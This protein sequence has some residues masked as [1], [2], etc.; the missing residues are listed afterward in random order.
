MQNYKFGKMITTLV[1]AAMLFCCLGCFSIS[2]SAAAKTDI[3]RDDLVVWY[4]AS[5]NSNG[6]QDYETTV[7]KDLTGNGN[8]MTV[9]L[10]ETNYWTDNAFHAE[11]NPTY[12]PDAV[13][14]VVNGDAYTVEMVLGEVD[15]TA[16]HWITLMCS[17]NDEFSLFV[18]QENDVLEYKY[19]DDNRDRPEVADGGNL[20]KNS[21]LSITFALTDPEAPLCTVYVNGVALDTGVPTVANIA[22]TLMW[23]HDSPARAWGGDVYGFRF[24]D[25]ALS[26]E[27]VAKNAS[28]DERNYRSGNYF[29]PEIEYDGSSEVIGGEDG[30][31]Y[32]SNIVTLSEAT[33]LVGTIGEYGCDN[34]HYLHLYGEHQGLKIMATTNDDGTITGNPFF[35]V[36]YPKFIRRAGLEQLSADDVKYIVVKIKVQ[37]EIEDLLFWG[38]SGE[39]ATRGGIDSCL[40]DNY[41]ECTGE[42][43]YMLFNMEDL[44]SGHINNFAFE[45]VNPAADAVVYI[46]EIAMFADEASAYTYAGQNAET[47]P[48]TTDAPTTETPTA[49]PSDETS[50]PEDLEDS[51]AAGAGNDTVA[52][53]ETTEEEQGGCGAVLSGAGVFSILGLTVLLLRK[54]KE[55]YC[56]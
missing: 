19:N 56:I 10:D 5:N 36:N 3:V 28:A 34:M 54:K 16:T 47:E 14:D 53:T 25:R 39:N 43:E 55:S 30:I 6:L 46:E 50:A 42:T 18:R 51:T 17:D 9:K 26:A 20:I 33:N 8:H 38:I 52:N 32:V 13:V 21:T 11:N 12:F 45:I 31:T 44:W 1:A 22:D 7:W 2:V 23:G 49:D 35:Y 15:F 29:E 48:E 4:D 41:P 40:P 27:E 24:Y 37:G